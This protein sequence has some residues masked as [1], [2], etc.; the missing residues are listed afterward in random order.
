MGYSARVVRSGRLC[1]VFSLVA[2]GG[3]ATTQCHAVASSRRAATAS[4]ASA[5]APDA[6]PLALSAQAR[7]LRLAPN[8]PF[9]LVAEAAQAPYL[10]AL[11]GAV[12]I[13]G[14]SCSLSGSNEYA[15]RFR[16]V[17]GDQVRRL[18]RPPLPAD[19]NVTSSWIRGHDE[20]DLWFWAHLDRSEG[21]DENL[22]LHSD[23][24]AWRVV[25][26]SGS[27]VDAL[28]PLDWYDGARLVAQRRS[29]GN[30]G[31]TS[32]E[33]FLV[34][35]KTTHAPPD[36]STLDFPEANLDYQQ[37]SVHYA[38]L[39]SHELFVAYT[40]QETSRFGRAQVSVGRTTATGQ[41]QLETVAIT[42]GG[43]SATS[44][45]FGHLRQG[46]VVVFW[47]NIKTNSL[48]PWLRLYD[49]TNSIALPGP[50][51]PSIDELSAVWLV[52][53]QIWARRGDA[54]WCFDG[55]SWSRMRPIEKG[56]LIEQAPGDHALWIAEPK[57][58][59]TRLDVNAHAHSVP[60]AAPEAPTLRVDQI[61]AVEADDIWIVASDS[62][63][64]AFVFRTKSP[65]ST[66]GCE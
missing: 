2:L 26:S 3:I 40:I 33:P 43:L 19:A 7:A 39:P 56:T 58:G 4:G 50:G 37:T 51:A 54:L 44:L 35:G 10:Y 38:A 57:G 23:G 42:T 15:A 28:Y 25:P 8:S 63:H 6:K 5:I 30:S 14:G 32:V 29:P 13:T 34:W 21:R 36:L 52:G 24:S 62:S 20:N 1:A 41:M 12:V 47:G 48:E 18:P 46:D 49:R 64:R 11:G 55:S 22:L 59:L 66:L 17:R 31:V 65:S 16:M 53:D 60:F 45:S 27:G 61:L 9:R